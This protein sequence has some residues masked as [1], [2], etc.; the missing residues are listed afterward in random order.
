MLEISFNVLS[1]DYYLVV[2]NTALRSINWAAVLWQQIFYKIASVASI[3]FLQSVYKA[4]KSI[5]CCE[6]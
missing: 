4:R 5:I 6:L 2:K 1:A 3:E